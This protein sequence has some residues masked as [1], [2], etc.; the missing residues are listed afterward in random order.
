MY[1]GVWTPLPASEGHAEHNFEIQAKPN[2]E[3]LF[4]QTLATE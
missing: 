2:L 4:L 3:M 1:L